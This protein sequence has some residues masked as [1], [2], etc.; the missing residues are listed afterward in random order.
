MDFMVDGCGSDRRK[1]GDV[2][3][4]SEDIVCICNCRWSILAAAA[5]WI[6]KCR[7]QIRTSATWNEVHHRRHQISETRWILQNVA[8]G[9]TVTCVSDTASSVAC[10][11]GRYHAAKVC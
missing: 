8:N 11:L 2:V 6:C 5:T 7:W 9:N 4:F 10:R 1:W 3:R